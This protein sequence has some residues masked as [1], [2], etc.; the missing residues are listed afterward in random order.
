MAKFH[1]HI[2]AMWS[3]DGTFELFSKED[4][5]EEE[6]SM[7][8]DAKEKDEEEGE[9]VDEDDEEEDDEDD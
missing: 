5:L 8:V 9:D 3:N 2:K 1:I 6:T 7:K 4:A